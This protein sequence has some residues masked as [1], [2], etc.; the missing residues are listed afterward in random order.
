MC[1]LLHTHC[2]LLHLHHFTQLAMCETLNQQLRSCFCLCEFS[3]VCQN[4][5]KTQCH[6]QAGVS[7]DAYIHPKMGN[8]SEDQNTALC[9]L[10]MNNAVIIQSLQLFDWRLVG[11]I[12]CLVSKTPVALPWHVQ[13]RNMRQATFMTLCWQKPWSEA[14]N[15]QVVR[16]SPLNAIF[17]KCIE[18]IS[19]N[20]VQTSPWNHG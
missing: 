8:K 18:G 3:L 14:G 12:G 16:P 5:T 4:L 13:W 15:F 10:C 2:C 20:L 17:Q 1:Y 11:F 7:H 9:L 6:F 19:L